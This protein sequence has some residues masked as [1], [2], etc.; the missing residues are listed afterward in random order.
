MKGVRGAGIQED[1]IK[2]GALE[3]YY[4]RNGAPAY[5]I[6]DVAWMNLEDKVWLFS[7]LLSLES[8]KLP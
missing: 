7:I 1:L 2:C 4:K 3:L 5:I 6:A 8:W